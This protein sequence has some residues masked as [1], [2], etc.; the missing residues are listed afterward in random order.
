MISFHSF[1]NAIKLQ[2]IQFH[3]YSNLNH[4]RSQLSNLDNSTFSFYQQICIFKLLFLRLIFFSIN[5]L[6]S[7]LLIIRLFEADNY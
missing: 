3:D 4:S 2:L 1:I 7:S 5:L 6:Y